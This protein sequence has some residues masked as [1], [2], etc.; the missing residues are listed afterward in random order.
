MYTLLTPRMALILYHT[1]DT[2]K[3]RGCKVP[4]S[5]VW[6]RGKLKMHDSF[7]SNPEIGNLKPEGLPVGFEISD[8]G[9]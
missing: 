2:V 4:N 5:A 1:A 3:E 8:F 7:N 9:I 6:F